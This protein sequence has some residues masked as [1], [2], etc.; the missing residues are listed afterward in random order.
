MSSASELLALRKEVLLARSSLQRL[1]I[2]RDAGALRESLRWPRAAA[3]V[4]ASPQGRS[5]LFGAL[6]LLAGRGRFARL[7]RGTAAIVGLGR[8]AWVLTHQGHPP[9]PGVAASAP[10]PDAVETR[11]PAA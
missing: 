7:V 2:A 3:A 8:L 6:L 10:A 1:K 11:F 5:V 9:D 4:V